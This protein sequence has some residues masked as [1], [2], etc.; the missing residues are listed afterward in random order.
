MR[1]N[2]SDNF[3]MLY[4]QKGQQKY[5]IRLLAL[6]KLQAGMTE[7]AVCELIGKTHKTVREWRRQ[8]EKNGIN[9]LLSIAPGRGRKIKANL[10]ENLAEDMVALQKEQKGG[11]IRCLD[12]VDLVLTKYG[13]KYSPSG[14]YSLL[15]RIGF[16]WIT[17]RSK[18]PK[19]DPQAM[20]DFKK[21]SKIW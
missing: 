3:E 9:G 2:W 12:I 5:G 7:T 17:S 4:K 16:S 15:G 1:V 19:S 8:Y 21:N 11:R 20:E 14:M 18:H 6:W 10:F 13:V